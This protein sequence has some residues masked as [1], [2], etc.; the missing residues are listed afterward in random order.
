M[1]NAPKVMVVDR[2]GRGHAVSDLFVRT[3]PTV[4]VL[5]VPGCPAI[6]HPRIKSASELRLDDFDG[7]VALAKREQV[8]FVF[9][10]NTAALADGLVDRLRAEGINAIGPDKAASRIEASKV[11]GKQMCR[12]YG[13][14]VAEHAVFEAP[15][16]AKDYVRNIGHDVV[17]K[18][19]GLC[20]GNGSY[21]CSSVAEAEAAINTIMVARDYGDVGAKLVIEQRLPG[22]EISYFAL[23]DGTSF[24]PLPMALD[25]KRADDGNVGVNGGGMGSV[26]PHPL[27]GERLDSLMAEQILKPLG[28]CIKAE[29]LNYNGII[30]IGAMLTEGQLRVLEFN[31]RLGDPEAEVVLPRINTDFVKVCDAVMRQ[32]LAGI[33]LDVSN[34]FFCNVVATQ[35]RTRQ[36][37][38]DGRNKG[39]YKGWPYGRYGKGYPI[40]GLDNI[41][42]AQARVFIGEA[43]VH[44]DKGLVSDG[45]RVIHVVGF[46]PSKDIAIQ[47]A[48]AHVGKVQ[49]DGV[50]FRSDIGAIYN[51]SQALS[52]AEIRAALDVAA[53]RC[54]DE[55]RIVATDPAPGLGTKK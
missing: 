18:A 5:Y 16:L 15:E 27:E 31:V 20:G 52:E 35:G 19:D 42:P 28:D 39:W 9:V 48:Y 55:P 46:G 3:N 11:Y 14:P 38:S 44:P 43:A 30:Y 21:V 32:E 24:K 17:V 29:G 13:I 8:D 45:G 1:S 51:N 34:Q 54:N 37:A 22:I 36:I 10:A 12:Q 26:S 47:I 4:E 25:Y 53:P 7:I 23:F 40:T 49:F 6:E 50:R 33:D 41:D 2:S